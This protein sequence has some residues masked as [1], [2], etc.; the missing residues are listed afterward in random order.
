M[1]YIG[2]GCLTLGG[3]LIALF[4]LKHLIVFLISGSPY[5]FWAGLILVILGIAAFILN[6]VIEGRFKSK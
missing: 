3:L 6:A 5:L 1:K 4:L 2:Y